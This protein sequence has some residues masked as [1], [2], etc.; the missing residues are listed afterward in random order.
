VEIPN[1]ERK[2]KEGQPPTKS[3]YCKISEN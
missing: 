3:T 2:K 1:V